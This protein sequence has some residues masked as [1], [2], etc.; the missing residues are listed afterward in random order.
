M[1]VDPDKK[2]RE[3]E[4]I[5][6]KDGIRRPKIHA[7]TAFYLL[8]VYVLLGM[9]FAAVFSIEIKYALVV[10]CVVFYATL[11]RGMSNNTKYKNKIDAVRASLLGKRVPSE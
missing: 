2:R 3:A 11:F 8:P 7:G 10:V 9:I 6:F 5:A 1:Y 4:A